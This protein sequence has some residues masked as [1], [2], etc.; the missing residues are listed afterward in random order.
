MIVRVRWLTPGMNN[1]TPHARPTATYAFA[2]DAWLTQSTEAYEADDFRFCYLGSRGSYTPL[3][4]DVYTSYSWSTNIAGRKRWRLFAPDDARWLR[5]FPERRTSAL[6]S[7]YVEMEQAFHA[8]KLGAY[9][10]GYEGWPG[11]G[12]VRE[13]VY[14]IEQ[15]VCVGRSPYPSQPGQ[16]IFVPS[17][18]YHEVENLTDCMSVRIYLLMPDQPQLVQCHESY[19]HVR[20]YGS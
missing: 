13:R 18:W 4:R 17:N 1:V 16:T 2:S 10:D 20:C 19:E 3:H 15:E 9:Q 5:Q 12:Q 7:R 11:W 6:A 14:E 8:G